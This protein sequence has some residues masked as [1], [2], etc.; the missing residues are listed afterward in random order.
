[1]LAGHRRRINELVNRENA[2]VMTLLVVFLL[3]AEQY[4]A[5]NT[6]QRPFW[7]RKREQTITYAARAPVC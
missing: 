1:M 5:E 6:T 3:R 2:N 7:P 4:S